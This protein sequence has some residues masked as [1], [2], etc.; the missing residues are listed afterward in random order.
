MIILLIISL[1]FLAFCVMH[2][3]GKDILISYVPIVLLVLNLLMRKK[4][5]KIYFPKEA[6]YFALCFLFIFSAVIFNYIAG[7]VSE[8]GISQ[9]IM[10]FICFVS[11]LLLLNILIH[12]KINKISL[13]VNIFILICV[14]ASIYSFLQVIFP[15]DVTIQN[16][17]RNANNAFAIWDPIYVQNTGH[18]P[19]GIGNLLRVTGFAAE[20]SLWAAFLVVP[21]CILIPRLFYKFRIYDLFCF[22]IIFFSFFLTRGRTGW[23][24]LV[25]ALTLF[26]TFILKG[27]QRKWFIM[28]AIIIICL[29]IFLSLFSSIISGEG[30][31][32]RVERSLGM[33][34]AFKMFMSSPIFGVGYGK[35]LANVSNI[36]PYLGEGGSKGTYAFNSYLRLLAETGII[37]FSLWVLFLKTLWDKL[38]LQYKYVQNN[39]SLKALWI[40]LG[41][42]FFSILFSWV[43][44]DGNNFIYIWFIFALV[45]S[46]PVIIEKHLGDIEMIK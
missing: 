29:A 12:Q 44:I 10:L 26:P 22:L 24:S 5:T 42:A 4:D 11:Y 14:A 17:L 3:N 31:W 39:T 28:F 7:K 27:G 25:L 37:G 13:F 40:G 15:Y 1:P 30:K 35:F 45:G 41:L 8:K 9:L 38:Y 46:L 20:P 34:N 36:S 6:R 18:F 21:L 33:V 32:S 19:N 16:S 2:Y 43:N 23:L